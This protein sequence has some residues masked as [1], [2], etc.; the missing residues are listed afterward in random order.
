MDCSGYLSLWFMQIRAELP[1]SAVSINCDNNGGNGD[2]EM[3]IAY[4]LIDFVLKEG[5]FFLHLHC[6]IHWQNVLSKIT[7][8]KRNE[9][10]SD[11]YILWEWKY[12]FPV[13]YLA[14]QWHDV[15]FKFCSHHNDPAVSPSPLS[16]TLILSGII[17]LVVSQSALQ[18]QLVLTKHL[19][20]RFKNIHFYSICRSIFW[21]KLS[22]TF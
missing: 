15:S 4:L 7:F 11:I 3:Q 12:W 19:S 8:T 10:F 2:A 18:L 5:Y 1:W 16:L 9:E 6:S 22:K 21:L 13:I 14:S 20:I 17:W